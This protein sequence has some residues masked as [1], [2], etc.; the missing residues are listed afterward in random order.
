MR[1]AMLSLYLVFAAMFA[2]ALSG[3]FLSCSALRGNTEVSVQ[4]APSR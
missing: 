2:T 4:K 3:L 1:L